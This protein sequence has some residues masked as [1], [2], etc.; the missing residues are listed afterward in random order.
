MTQTNNK[1]R[2]QKIL[3]KLSKRIN[4]DRI[5]KTNGDLDTIKLN[6]LPEVMQIKKDIESLGYNQKKLREDFFVAGLILKLSK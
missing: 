6:L 1:Q 2:V 5:T 4:P 3:I